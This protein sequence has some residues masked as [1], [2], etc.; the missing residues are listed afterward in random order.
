MNKLLTALSCLLLCVSL[1]AQPISSASIDSLA[2]RVLKAFD[3]PGVAVGIV[4]DGKIIHAKG[5]GV[6]KLGGVEKMDANTMVGIASNSKA[7][8]AAALAVLV[9][10]KK[11]AWDTKVRDIIPEFKLYDAYVT[12]AF[13]IADLLTHRSGMGLGA[14]DL[15][16]FPD[17][18]NFT[19]KDIIY[20]LRFL[21]PVSGFRTKFDYDNLL[22]IVAGEVVNRVSGLSWDDFVEQRLMRPLGM[23]SSAACYSRLADKTNSIS[24][25]A[26]V[27]GVVKPIPI[28]F[29]ET[30]NAAGGIWS[31]INELSMW[32]IAQMNGGAYGDSLKKKLF[33]ATQHREMWTMQT[34]MPVGGPGAYNT[35]YSGYGLGWFLNDAKGYQQVSHTGG[36]LGIVTQVTLLPELKLGIIVLTNQLSGYAFTSI[37]NTIKD[38]YFGMPYRDRVAQYKKISDED[39]AEAKAVTDGIW[40]AIAAAQKKAVS[41]IPDSMLLGT[42]ADSWFGKITIS[43][44]NNQ[45]LFSSQRSPK[46]TGEMLP[47][48]ANT[49]VVKWFDR[50]MDADAFA[51]FK[52][53]EEGKAVGLSMKA[54]SPLT[55]FS[56]DFHDLDLKRVE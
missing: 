7:F 31:N 5:Y 52:L 41:A 20:N 2:E 56:F 48:K 38:A 40:T 6:R 50:S 39:K 19:L 53:D 17:S 1:V 35:H 25:H 36:L 54:I 33:S 23:K 13:T 21:K 51:S 12:E 4:K 34:I 18:S 49:Y 10:E 8:T 44:K 45:Y 9:D 27:E 46:L 11:L 32:A 15:M 43:K 42:Y 37:T 14:G 28:D 30:G 22:Y 29:S 24:A 26:P 3:V 47:Y 16:M 55:D